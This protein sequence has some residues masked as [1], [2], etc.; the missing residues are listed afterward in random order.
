MKKV[1][2]VSVIL[3]WIMIT[4]GTQAYETIQ[5]IA[6]ENDTNTIAR[7]LTEG[8]DVNSA[9]SSRGCTVLH[10]A[11]YYNRRQA[12]EFL[13]EQEA[14][15]N[16]RNDLGMTPLHYA[17][18]AGH[19]TMIEILLAKK[20]EVNALDCQGLSPLHLAAQHGHSDIIKILL[21]Y[22]ADV[23]IKTNFRGLT[24]LHWA[25]FWGDTEAINTLIKN[26][27]D[28]NARD[29]NGYTPFIWAEQHDRYEAARLL[30]R[31][32]SKRHPHR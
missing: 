10:W 17:A 14:E 22:G 3:T 16:A 19:K 25:A 4:T 12:A 5:V 29:N 15:V 9:D 21:D 31:M 18:L 7:L 26:G 27:A 6:A 32:G 11:A 8:F 23:S 30:A 28:K 20:A 1:L 2:F 13:L 24:P